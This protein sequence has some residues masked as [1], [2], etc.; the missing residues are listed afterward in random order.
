MIFHIANIAI[1]CYICV[2]GVLKVY[3]YWF[4]RVKLLKKWREF[5]EGGNDIWVFLQ[6]GKHPTHRAEQIAGRAEADLSRRKEQTE[7]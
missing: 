5:L 1:L 3:V 6:K 2:N 7:Y 4:G